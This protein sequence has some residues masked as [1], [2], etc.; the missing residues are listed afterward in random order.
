MY[1]H[2][3]WPYDSGP[4]RDEEP[5]AKRPPPTPAAIDAMRR[6]LRMT[7]HSQY[8]NANDSCSA[9]GGCRLNGCRTPGLYN[10]FAPVFHCVFA[11]VLKTLNT[12]TAGSNDLSLNRNTRPIFSCRYFAV[13][14]IT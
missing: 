14:L 10:W 11:P 1:R 3:S 8:L 6:S 9:R 12:F 2:R 4:G 13:S 5:C 7:D